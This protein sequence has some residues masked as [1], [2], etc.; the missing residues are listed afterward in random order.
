[1]WEG[2]RFPTAKILD[3]VTPQGPAH[4][5]HKSGHASWA[6]SQALRTAGI[7]AE[8][9]DPPGGEIQRDREGQPTGIFFETAIDLIQKHVP[10]ESPGELADAMRQAQQNCWRYGLVGV[11]DF[12]GA[13]C[14]RAFQILQQAGDLGIRVVKNIPCALIDHAV[15]LGLRS[16]YGNEWLRIGGIKIFADGALGPMTALMIDPYE[17]QPDNRG[18]TVVDK[19]EMM[20]I[21][22]KSSANHLSVTVH[23][24]GDRANH[25]VLD[26]YEAV[27]GEEA[28]RGLTGRKLRH[29]IEHAQILHPDDIRRFAELD[30]IASMQ[31]IHATSDMI[32]A[33]SYW[34]ERARTSYAWRALLETGVTLVFGTDAPVERLDPLPN[35]YAAVNR[36][37]PSGEYAPDGWYPEEKLTLEETIHG[38]T[39]AAAYTAGN[40]ANSGSISPGKLADLTIFD[41]DIFAIDPLELDEIGIAGTVI[42]G[43]F[44]YRDF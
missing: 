11:H 35:I 1:V 29:R 19:E 9:P 41:R 14:F 16:G 2:R 13:D 10:D 43:E 3:T 20:E 27:R 8:T 31:P 24:I 28:A 17:G 42:N 34:G 32:M 37:R 22:S 12:D 38:M 30:I 15:A 39:Y 44:K 40:E 7:T 33:D 18:I 5:K 23:A 25:D 4:L 21:A 36:R 6:N 26:V